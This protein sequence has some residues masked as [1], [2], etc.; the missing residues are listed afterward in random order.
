L[1][2]IGYITQQYVPFWIDGIGT[3]LQDDLSSWLIRQVIISTVPYVVTFIALFIALMML[4]VISVS[5]GIVLIISLLILTFICVTWILEDASDSVYQ[6]ETQVRN[7]IS[8]NWETNK[9]QF[10]RYLTD[11]VIN[12][13]GLS[14]PNGCPIAQETIEDKELFEKYRQYGQDCECCK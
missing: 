3:I 1:Y 12:P 5:V 7:K 2:T 8:Q 10:F 6:V 13:D 11:A 14:C 9:S 4:G